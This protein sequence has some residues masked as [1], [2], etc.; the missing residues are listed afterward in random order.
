MRRHLFAVFAKEGLDHLRDSRSLTSAML[1]PIF[2]PVLFAVMMNVIASWADSGKPVMLAVEGVDRAPNLVAFVKRFGVEVTPAPA[3][4]E[5]KV[6]D[7][8]FDAALILSEDYE[9]RWRAG[10]PAELDLLTDS[11]RRAAASQ[12]ARAKQVLNAYSGMIASQRLLA[13]GVSPELAQTLAVQEV[14]LATPEKLAAM[15]LNMIPIFLVLACFVGGMNVAIDATAGERERGSLEP[16]LVNPVSRGALVLGKWLTTVLV[17][18]FAVALTLAGFAIAMGRVPL[19]VL[20]VKA[21]L[22][23]AEFGALLLSVLPLTMFASAVQ[24]LVATYARSFKEAQTYLSLLLFVPTIPGLLLTFT[25]LDPNLALS[26]VPV[27]GQHLLAES[28]LSG[29]GFDF[30]RWVLSLVGIAPLAAVCLWA[31]TR[32]LTNERIIFGR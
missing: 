16:L 13:R 32:L 11:S 23:I 14:D 24:M 3:D 10:R 12:V 18:T 8:T 30:A 7:G 4:V 15:L 25:P 2:G 19:E 22:G 26:L 17:A 31:C 29:E 27:L 28:V 1:F 20:G 5:E 21:S 9:E 6:R